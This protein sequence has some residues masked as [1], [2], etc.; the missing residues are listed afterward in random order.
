M[1]LEKCRCFRRGFIHSLFGRRN[2]PGESLTVCW[3]PSVAKER[4]QREESAQSRVEINYKVRKGAMRLLPV[5]A[6][7][8]NM[9]SFRLQPLG[10]HHYKVIVCDFPLNKCIY[11]LKLYG[12]FFQSW[13]A[14]TRIHCTKR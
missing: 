11:W 2:D 14:D 7:L 3:I 10:R 12:L 4:Q 5:V 6:A 1:H 9:A 8:I 13:F